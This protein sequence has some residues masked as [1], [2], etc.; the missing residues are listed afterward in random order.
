MTGWWPKKAGKDK[1]TLRLREKV[2]KKTYTPDFTLQWKS[3][4]IVI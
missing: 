4:F 3:Y 2:Q 1:K